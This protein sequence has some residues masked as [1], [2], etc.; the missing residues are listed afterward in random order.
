MFLYLLDKTYK[1]GGG[2]GREGGR[3]GGSESGEMAQSW[4][5][6]FNSNTYQKLK[7][8]THNSNPS[9]RQGNKLTS[10]SV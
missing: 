4:M 1:K 10:Q 9:M 8:V 5:L 3:E 7:M 2:E 6:N